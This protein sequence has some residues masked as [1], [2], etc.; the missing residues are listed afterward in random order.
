MAS[1]RELKSGKHQVRWREPDGAGGVAEPSKSFTNKKDALALLA[2]VT[3]CE[4]LGIAYEDAPVVRVPLIG[5]GVSAYQATLA[6]S[7]MPLTIER[8]KSAYAAFADFLDDE[9]D[10]GD[11]TVAM[12]SI[13]MLGRFYDWLKVGRH[14][15]DRGAYTKQRIVNKIEGAWAWLDRNEWHPSV[16]RAKTIDMLVEADDA[17]EAPTFDE[18]GACVRACVSEGPRR[19]A[20]ILYYTGVRTSIAETIPG[21][22]FNLAAGTMKVPP[23]K[24]LP[25][26]VIPLSPYFLGELRTWEMGAGPACAWDV[27]N[28]TTRSRLNEAWA[29]AKVR[30]EAWEGSPGR[31]FRRGLTTGLCVLGADKEKAE[32]YVG[33]GAEG[34]RKRYLHVGALPFEPIAALIPRIESG[35]VLALK[36]RA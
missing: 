10:G 20:T 13:D 26:Y 27:V 23:Q 12:L 33:R 9:Y 4:E 6:R 11:V 15:A 22:A 19:V 7:L 30:K 34:A 2:V 3:R 1:I 28:Q 17:V 31:A 18:M 24:G 29:R 35:T 32:L 5:E 14:D 8:Y 36:E 21:T 16:P 25:G